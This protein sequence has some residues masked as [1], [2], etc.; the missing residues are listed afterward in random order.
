MRPARD[1]ARRLVL[2]A[3]S[4]L[5]IVSGTAHARDSI[6]L[7]D[8]VR[9]KFHLQR[10]LAKSA[11][12]SSF[13]FG[14]KAAGWKAVV[15]DW[16]AD[17]IDTFGLYDHRKGLFVLRNENDKAQSNLRF[18]FGPKRKKLQPI[19]G[20]WDG[21]GTSTVGVFDPENGE[22]RLRNH[23]RT[24]R[25]DTRFRFGRHLTSPIAV[26]GDWD[27]D[28]VDSF[29]V[30]DPKRRLFKLRDDN[31]A[32]PAHYRFVVAVSGKGWVPVAGD[33]NNDGVDSVALYHPKLKKL[34]LVK[35]FVTGKISGVRKLDDS[36]RGE[37][38]LVG[39]W[40]RKEKTKVVVRLNVG[41]GDY[42]DTLGRQWNADKG[43]V[44]GSIG[45]SSEPIVGTR[46]DLLYQSE[47][48]G[49][50]RGDELRVSLQVPDG[51]Y[52]V[53][54]HFVENDVSEFAAG[55]R[56]FDVSIE[57][58]LAID[59][60]DV[61]AR[62]GA[63]TATSQVVP[64][65]VKD[66]RLNIRFDRWSGNPQLSALEILRPGMPSDSDGDGEDAGGNDDDSNDDASDQESGTIRVNAGGD[67]Y[68]DAR[69]RI[70]SADSGY[71]NGHDSLYKKAV[72]GTNEDLL[73]RSRQYADRDP[74]DP[75]LTYRF[76]L[77]NGKYK[78]RLHFAELKADYHKLGGR[79]LDVAAQGRVVISN[80]DV[81]REAGP[82]AALVK[83]ITVD[84]T[85]QQLTLKF[86]QVVGSPYVSAIEILPAD[87]DKDKDKD[88]RP[89][90]RLVNLG[91]TASTES[92]DG[93]QV[94][95]GASR[96]S[97]VLLLS[98]L[99]VDGSGFDPKRPGVRYDSVRDLGVGR[100]ESACFR[101]RTFKGGIL[102][103]LSAA[104]C[105]K[106]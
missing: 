105:G 6:A 33:W 56:V 103:P 49:N 93:Y 61:Y 82:N 75:A 9:G 77:K 57:G 2:L 32:G 69:G 17:G 52:R 100:G 15:G 8:G 22:F 35:N 25:A 12:E 72:S 70:W 4:L 54:L 7:Y 60:L 97:T 18:R 46:D 48:W 68:V 67:R 94:F 14:P 5:A 42:I 26:V 106:I 76:S 64:A 58:K 98:T 31:S 50:P 11:G 91:W 44:R 74:S 28:G 87:S 39:S 104:V 19:A 63:R 34:Q 43:I 20:D 37:Q 27:G 79:I 102:S 41:G 36:V 71:S 59:D 92:V 86:L 80:L 99:K 84:V 55:L 16:D 30:Y 21:D 29:G 66:G 65:N 10:T 38:V 88:T 95:F 73:Y 78:V 24:G 13:R 1:N 62:V 51:N 85:S 40:K 90:S 101:V 83:T 81:F 89:R 96:E 45:E 53:K 47:R 23:N 3:I